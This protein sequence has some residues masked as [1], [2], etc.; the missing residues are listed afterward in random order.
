M[1]SVF[2]GLGCGVVGIVLR[3]PAPPRLKRGLLTMAAH[4][5]WSGL[6]SS[7][8]RYQ[9]QRRGPSL[10]ATTRTLTCASWGPVPRSAW[11]LAAWNGRLSSAGNAEHP[12]AGNARRED[13]S[14]AGSLARALGLGLA[15]AHSQDQGRY[16]V[17]AAGE[18][19][20]ARTIQTQAGL[21]RAHAYRA[22]HGLQHEDDLAY[23]F[24][25]LEDA[26]QAGGQ[27]LAQM[28]VEARR[29]AEGRLLPAASAAVERAE[30][31][32]R[33]TQASG[34]LALPP[35]GRRLGATLRPQG[36][37]AQQTVRRVEALAQVFD[38]MGVL[39]TTARDASVLEERQR[40]LSRIAQIKCTRHEPITVLNAL[41]TWTELREFME[42]RNRTTLEGLD[43]AVF[44]QEGTR[45][46][47][48]ALNSLK[49]LSKAA[50]MEWNLA[51]ITIPRRPEAPSGRRG[52]ALV[53]EPGMLRFLEEEV[54][55]MHDSRNP[56]W[57]AALASWLVAVGVLRNKHLSRSMPTKISHS[58]IHFR[59]LQGKQSVTREE[60]F[61]WSCPAAFTT[62]WPW[63]MKWLAFVQA[64]PATKQGEPGL[65]K[66][67][68]GDH[69]S[70]QE[71]QVTAQEIFRGCIDQ[72]AALTTYSWRRLFPTI[73][74]LCN[75]PGRE[76]VALS[77]WTD[78]SALTP[79]E[80]MPVHYSGARQLMSLKVKHRCLAILG[81][82]WEYECWETIPAGALDAMQPELEV[83]VDRAASQDQALLWRSEATSADIERAFNFVRRQS[84]AAEEAKRER[85][86]GVP[87][88]ATLES[89]DGRTLFL[90]Q[91]MRNGQALCPRYQAGEPC[92]DG[93]GGFGAQCG[94]LHRCAVTLTTG[95]ACGLGHRAKDCRA[96]RY[97]KEAPNPSAGP[98][99][100][101]APLP[102]AES[103]AL[104][105]DSSESDQDP[106]AKRRREAPK[107]PEQ[108]Y[109][110]EADYGGDE[111]IWAAQAGLPSGA[112][113]GAALPASPA[114]GKA[115]P[116]TP[117]KSPPRVPPAMP[118]R[119]QS[120]PARS[121]QE[122]PASPPSAG[123][124]A[125][126]LRPAQPRRASAVPRAPAAGEASAPL[127][128]DDSHYD[129]LATV[130]G[131]SAPAP[132][133][134][135]SGRDL[136]GRAVVG[137]PPHGA[138]QGEVPE[139]APP[140]LLLR[141]RARETGRLQA[142][143]GAPAEDG[144]R[145]L[146]AVGGLEPGLV[147]SPPE[148]LVGGDDRGPLHGRAPPRC[149]CGCADVRPAPRDL[150][151]AGGGAHRG[152]AP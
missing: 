37:S 44:I 151:G 118:K 145:R 108:G 10:S 148:L 16:A 56:R 7:G 27:A 103:V 138:E 55:R 35:P 115:I 6:A 30:G 12:Y 11:P 9:L 88:P 15:M 73:A 121:Q 29:S 128:F 146:R 101:A 104:E 85:T 117:P 33:P 52:Q 116:K 46:P 20:D 54:Q 132:D 134:D 50:Q 127:R 31:E 124:K 19:H 66:N 14:C 39:S 95:R 99:S 67:M 34:A 81:R 152:P 60:G 53:V 131:K 68:H 75:F 110:F 149:Y 45:G 87:M 77:D 96:K 139:G 71:C 143:G 4:R 21:Q 76:L 79:E 23:A 91:F 49:W 125:P 80:R 112:Y 133:E 57:T 47:A 1:V 5:L 142:S 140:G 61:Y 106:P 102:V 26:Q 41:R 122:T 129:R 42:K 135:C 147:H 93:E 24:S 74:H 58:T 38:Q 141:R 62:G 8:W 111:E 86:G 63:A 82:V 32:P 130:G 22:T 126:Q 70:I 114:L 84:Q 72:E 36:D 120:P 43:L 97:L 113:P 48:R 13:A 64:L 94:E 100:A 119:P 137:R 107:E 90:T 92:P 2:P 78:K 123:P 98:S 136:G 83:L 65:C 51:Q 3:C 144:D 40:A 69:F 105:T 59:C 28:W 17:E 18:S 150:L 89:E 109:D 25:H